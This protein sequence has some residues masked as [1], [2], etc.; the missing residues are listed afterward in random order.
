AFGPRPPPPLLAPLLA[1]LRHAR[2]RDAED[3]RGLLGGVAQRQELR[4]PP[5]PLIQAVEV[6]R[7]VN[8]EGRLVAS[9]VSCSCCPWACAYRFS[10]EFRGEDGKDST[11]KP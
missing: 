11:L 1:E 7:P 8:A 3:A 10:R 6:R 5:V 9:K 2:P 4:Q